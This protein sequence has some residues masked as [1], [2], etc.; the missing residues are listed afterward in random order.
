MQTTTHDPRTVILA[1]TSPTRRVAWIAIAT[2]FLAWASPATAQDHRW[3][4]SVNG[5]SQATSTDFADNV[6]FTEFIEEGDF[7]AAYG[8]DSGVIFDIGGGVRLPFDLGIGLG[9]SRFD[10]SNDASVNARIPHPFFFDRDR[11]I[12]GSAP[13]LTRREN[14]VHVQ[15]RWF[16]PTPEPVEL[17][18]F[19]GPTFSS[20]TQGLVTA[21][22][23]SQTYPFDVASFTAAASGTQTES[24]VGYNVGADVGFFFSRYVGIGALVRFSRASLDLVSEDSGL[25]SVDTGGLHAGGGLR[26][27][28]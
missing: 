24:A 3:F 17:S 18:V 22:E 10:K 27:R 21:V 11:A 25:V 23:F 5:G 8:I 12:A 14:S 13:S 6:V 19:G 20:V 7:D 1:M 15:V 26:L 2:A 16:V 28:F 9:F 4:I